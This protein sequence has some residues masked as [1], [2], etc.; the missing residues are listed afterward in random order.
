MV[1]RINIPDDA[2]AIVDKDGCNEDK[3]MNTEDFT[4]Y[5]E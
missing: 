5:I 2:I 1:S 3:R 4:P